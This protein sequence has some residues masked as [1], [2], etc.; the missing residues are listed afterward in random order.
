VRPRILD[1]VLWYTVKS[2]KKQSQ[3]GIAAILH[4]NG[5]I[6]ILAKVGEK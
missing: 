3:A 4:Q 5:I 2:R 1:S 6:K